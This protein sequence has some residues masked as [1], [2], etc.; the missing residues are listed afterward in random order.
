[1]ATAVAAATR[2]QPSKD[3]LV[4]I[5]RALV[6]RMGLE[7]LRHYLARIDAETEYLATNGGGE[8]QTL[9]GV[10]GDARGGG[11]GDVSTAPR[12]KVP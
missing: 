2:P 4:P 3:V 7:R 9:L 8:L 1:L 12:R 11:I 5:P 10:N 6:D